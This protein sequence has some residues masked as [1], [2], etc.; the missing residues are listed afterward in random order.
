MVNV[1]VAELC[2]DSISKSLQQGEGSHYSDEI[3][4]KTKRIKK[5]CHSMMTS[6]AHREDPSSI[7]CDQN[8]MRKYL[9]EYFFL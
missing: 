9:L 8:K 6:P 4:T 1:F 7:M 2:I 3:F 5:L